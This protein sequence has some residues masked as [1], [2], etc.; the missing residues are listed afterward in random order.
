MFSNDCT[1]SMVETFFV[2]LLNQ[3][4][5]VLII[6]DDIQLSFS[7]K[8]FELYSDIKILADKARVNFMLLSSQN[9]VYGKMK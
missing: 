6:I 1:D 4:K 7:F 8:T 3:D 2:D 5:N 9:T